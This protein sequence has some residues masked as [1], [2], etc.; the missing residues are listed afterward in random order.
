MWNRNMRPSTEDLLSLR[1]REPMDAAVRARMLTSRAAAAEIDRLNGVRD[2]MRTLPELTPPAGTWQRI[3]ASVESAGAAQTS[4]RR[5]QTGAVV[6]AVLAAAAVL[7]IVY[8]LA[9]TEPAGRVAPASTAVSAAPDSISQPAAAA[10][11]AYAALVEESVRLEQ[12]LAGV[13][14]QRPVMTG[15]TASTIAVLEDRISFIDGQLTLAALEGVEL[16]RKQTLWRERV[17]VMNAL[18][19]VRFAQAQPF[20]Y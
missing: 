6:A 16:P 13:R 9:P 7:L 14:Y 1:D 12:L 20:R 18:V 11:P 8:P 17:D 10:A 4:W 3:A 19:Q 5:G 2:A 15:G